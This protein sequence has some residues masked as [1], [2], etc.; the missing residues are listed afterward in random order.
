[1]RRGEI[2]WADFGEPRGSEPGYR[3]PVV[4]V[5]ADVMNRSRIGTAIVIPLTSTLRLADQPGNVLLP[6]KATKLRKPSVANVAQPMTVDREVL[7]ERVTLLSPSLMR[8]IDAG[9]R[10]TL[11]L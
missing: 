2:W 1:M 4:V 7:E 6:A 9:L 5:S 8:Q 3:R 10:L 11:D